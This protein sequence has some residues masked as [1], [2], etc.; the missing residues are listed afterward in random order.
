MHLNSPNPAL[1]STRRKPE[2][3]TAFTA[4]PKDTRRTDCKVCRLAIFDT[5]RAVWVRGRLVGL[6]HAPCAAQPGLTVV[7]QQRPTAAPAGPA[8]VR[9]WGTKLTDRQTQMLQLKAD[10]LTD[11]AIAAQLGVSDKTVG[12]ILRHARDRLGVTTTAD[13]V[14]VAAQLG[15]IRKPTTEGTT[16]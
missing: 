1:P 12:N 4:M 6:V 14:T 13:A 5:D 2:M 16:P 7:T 9:S 11:A 10:Q 15:L 3:D 8:P